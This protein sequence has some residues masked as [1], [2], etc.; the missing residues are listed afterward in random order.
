M[1]AKASAILKT[2]LP[3]AG[4][5]GLILLG[6]AGIFFGHP[7]PLAQAPVL[8]LATPFC[9][10]LLARR[11]SRARQALA[12]GWLTGLGGQTLSLHWLTLPMTQVGGLPL[13]LAVL[14]LILLNAY[15]ALFSALTC[16]AMQRGLSL[17]ARG[18]A[19]KQGSSFLA[20]LAGGVA[21]AG[22]EVLGGLLFT[23]FPWLVLSAA[24]VPWPEWIQAASLVGGYGLSGLYAAGACLLAAA[25]ACRNKIAP[26][27]GGLILC[28]GLPLYGAVRLESAAEDISE[29]CL[30]VLLVQGNI[31]QNQKWLPAFQQAAVDKYMR[32][33]EA[34]LRAAA[35][36]RDGAALVLWPET[37]M[38][39]YY[40][41]AA[42]DYLSEE[43][44]SFVRRLGITLAFGTLGASR[45][46]SGSPALF[47]RVQIL[48]PEGRGLAN[49]DKEHLVPF[50]EY[51]PLAADFEFLK[52]IMQ[53]MDF[54][55]GRNGPPGALPPAGARPGLTRGAEAAKGIVP[56]L[57]ICYEVIFPELARQRVAEGANLL[58]TV[59]NDAWFGA[60]QA[61]L[62]HLHLAA[63]RAVELR[64]PLV[65]AT[66]TGYTAAIDSFGRIGA[67]SALF[68]ETSL[69][70]KVRADSQLTVFFSLH[71]FLR[72]FSACVALLLLFPFRR[73]GEVQKQL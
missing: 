53:G 25:L 49:Y 64:R 57:L 6:A 17:F 52:R 27:L 1:I 56:G 42:S 69:S 70:V 16:L 29:P 7:N 20:A 40:R 43:L 10:F 31:D 44:R 58:I 23:G 14:G 60:T 46:D 39:F 65:R 22:F 18:S 15:L 50:G 71:P 54:S 13:P 5:S 48:S 73:A 55:P 72:I 26:L 62:Q 41:S 63:M 11:A 24:F 51:I 38:P 35:G 21:W 67:T 59:S 8:V 3:D 33:T 34:G 9:L 12:H 36:E 30:S 32:L 4:Q 47:N 61:P 66:N 37:A 19:E 68:T 45:T 2:C 28:L